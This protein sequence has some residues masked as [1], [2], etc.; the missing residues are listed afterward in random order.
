VLR[1]LVERFLERGSLDAPS[2]LLPYASYRFRQ[3]LRS[4]RFAL[5][6]EAPAHHRPPARPPAGTAPA[7]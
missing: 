1:R 7:A 5:T 3:A 2:L 4:V 6:Y